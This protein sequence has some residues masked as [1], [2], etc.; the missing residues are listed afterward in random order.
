MVWPSCGAQWQSVCRWQ[1]QGCTWYEAGAATIALR[2]SAQGLCTAEYMDGAA[3]DA[4]RHT[5]PRSE[6]ALDMAAVQRLMQRAAIDLGPVTVGGQ[7]FATVK[8]LA[9]AWAARFAVPAQIA[10]WRAGCVAAV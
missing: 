3:L 8:A 7:Q 1:A 2:P 4:L 5:D 10:R 6:L 9:A